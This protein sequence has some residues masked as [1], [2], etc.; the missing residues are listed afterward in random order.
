MTA[1]IPLRPGGQ[2]A[3]SVCTTRVIV[4]RAPA[5][6][7]PVIACG[8]SPMVPAAPGKAAAST[9]ADAVTL[10]GKRYVDANQSLE[11]LCT[12]SGVGELSCDGV[13]MTLKAANALPASD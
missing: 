8:G 3:S 11:V 10:I 7:N 2:L 6:G 9:V 1:P 4:V 13:A 12:S 5:T